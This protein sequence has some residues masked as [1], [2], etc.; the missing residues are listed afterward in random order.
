[1]FWPLLRHYPL[2]NMLCR[3]ARAPQPLD[4]LQL[5]CVVYPPRFSL[6]SLISIPGPEGSRR[7]ILKPFGLLHCARNP[8]LIVHKDLLR[9][10]LCTAQGESV[11][12]SRSPSLAIPVPFRVVPIAQGFGKVVKWLAPEDPGPL[13]FLPSRR[14]C[15]RKKQPFA[16]DR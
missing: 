2:D 1:M 6:E 8:I 3:G 12:R 16:I 14:L 13:L 9:C 10:S 4:P 5:A 7:D 15:C 11:L